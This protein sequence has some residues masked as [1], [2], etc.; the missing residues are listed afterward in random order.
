M[1]FI[2]NDDSATRLKGPPHF[3]MDSITWKHPA[4]PNRVTRVSA[5]SETRH[6]LDVQV[7]FLQR[8]TLRSIII[9]EKLLSDS[10]NDPE[11]RGTFHESQPDE[12]VSGR[13][14]QVFA[15]KEQDADQVHYA[16]FSA[17]KKRDRNAV[18]LKSSSVADLKSAA[19]KPEGAT[20]GHPTDTFLFFSST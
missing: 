19:G 8:R 7:K 4:P 12:S 18:P 14:E 1:Q 16:P 20:R 17:L 10:R 13:A 9:D 5:D 3:K 6:P 2:D 15:E 11:C